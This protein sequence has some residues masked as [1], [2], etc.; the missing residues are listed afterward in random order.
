MT[1]SKIILWGPLNG[2]FVFDSF[3]TRRHHICWQ[4]QNK[5]KHIKKKFLL[6]FITGTWIKIL[7]NL[8]QLD[9]SIIK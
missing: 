4:K 8:D 9:H 1:N 6:I 2:K 7:I 5:P 3:K